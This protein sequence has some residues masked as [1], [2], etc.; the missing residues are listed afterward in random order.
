MDVVLKKKETSFR[1]GDISRKTTL[2]EDYEY[3]SVRVDK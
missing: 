2:S 1:S 3:T